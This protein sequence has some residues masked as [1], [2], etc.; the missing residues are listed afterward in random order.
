MT[1]E[2]ML[3]D[4][5]VTLILSFRAHKYRS[6]RGIFVRHVNQLSDMAFFCGSC[7]TWL[8]LCART[9]HNAKATEKI[10]IIR[11]SHPSTDQL[12]FFT[13]YDDDVRTMGWWAIRTMSASHRHTRR[14]QLNSWKFAWELHTKALC[15][16]WMA[17]KN[18]NSFSV[19]FSLSISLTPI[20]T[21]SFAAY[22]SVIH[23]RA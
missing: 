18:C 8:W 10:D 22:L 7:A 2:S 23:A 3:L 5:V 20:F 21:S 1:F 16:A 15:C 12:P 9:S 11:R 4:F 13:I 19:S 17:N 14:I 6:I